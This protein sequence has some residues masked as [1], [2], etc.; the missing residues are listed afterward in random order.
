MNILEYAIEV[1]NDK[2]S[3]KNIIDQA[4]NSDNSWEKS[5]NEYKKLYEVVVN[6]H[7]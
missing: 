6:S 7:K 2:D 1:Y 3:W 4:M 5:A